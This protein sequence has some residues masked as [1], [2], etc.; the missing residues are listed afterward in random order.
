MGRLFAAALV[1]LALAGQAKADDAVDLDLVLAV[2][3]SGSVNAARYELQKQGYAGAF[4][5]PRVVDAIAGGAHRAIAVTLMQWTGPTLHVVAVGWT[6]VRDRAS[7]DALAERLAAMPRELYGGGT[8]LSGAIDYSMELLAQSPY[9]GERRVIDIS[10]DGSNNRG[11]PAEL[12][13]D[14]AVAAGVVINGLPILALEP[15]LDTYY[16]ANVIGGAGAFVVAAQT[17]EVFAQA[18]LDKLVNEIAWR[19]DLRA[20]YAVR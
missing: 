16:H 18:I 9:R 10:G 17:Y 4:R 12:A 19:A 3:V 5:N 15:D 13:R 8:S 1:A 6:V 7:A 2:D 11:R 20:R 14:E